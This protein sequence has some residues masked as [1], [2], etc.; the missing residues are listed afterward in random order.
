MNTE[1]FGYTLLSIL[2]FIILGFAVGS[3]GTLIGAGGGF[4][5]APV[6]LFLYP[7]ERPETIT[8][9]SLAV[10]FFNAFSGS[11]AYARHKRIDYRS[12]GIFAAAS[13][14]GAI[15]GALTT[16]ILP[17]GIFNLIFGIILV[18]IGAYL[19]LKPEDKTVTEDA[20]AQVAH[21][22]P[23][24]H[25]TCTLIDSEGHTYTWSYSMSTG[26]G[27]SV[28]VGYLS[29]LLGIGG[30]IIHV[31]ALTRLLRFPVPIATATSHFILAL[32]ALAGT[33]VHILSGAFAHGIRRTGFLAV[34]VV[35]G[36][37]LGAALSHRVQG[38]W[39]LR[40]LAIALCL[41]GVRLLLVH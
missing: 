36:A 16:T 35:L 41:V 19:L 4:L 28:G 17:R 29:S 8:A 34:G 27:I 37:Q 25:T 3:F 11:L 1:L 30:G 26:I 14:P 38:V 21:A 31:P 20:S 32:V 7:N 2:G 13:L 9:I 6:L 39:I 23:S 10:V 12:G 5:L 18:C 33:I 24:N 15:L 22:I 40:G